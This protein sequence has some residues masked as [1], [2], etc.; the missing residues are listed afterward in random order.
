[1]A[2]RPVCSECEH[3]QMYKA[4]GVVGYEAVCKA[5]SRH[6]RMLDWQYGLSHKWTRTELKDRIESRICPAWCPKW[7]RMT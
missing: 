5:R 7:R 4:S 6:G 2:E 3:F 1:M